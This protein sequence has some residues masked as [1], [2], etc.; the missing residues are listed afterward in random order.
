MTRASR[1]SSASLLQLQEKEPTAGG[2]GGGGGGS[3]SSISAGGPASATSPHKQHPQHQLPQQQQQQAMAPLPPRVLQVA[4][5]LN[6]TE[7]Q[8][9]M[10]AAIERTRGLD[11]QEAGEADMLRLSQIRCDVSEEARKVEGM[12]APGMRILLE[13]TAK[14]AVYVLGCPLA[15][16]KKSPSLFFFTVSLRQRTPT[17]PRP[18]CTTRTTSSTR[19]DEHRGCRLSGWPTSSRRWTLVCARST[20]SCLG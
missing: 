12:L 9:D 10:V 15:S 3:S 13:E 11:E 4:P 7:W 1:T 8:R 6:V 16:L 17:L 2:G 19:G 18:S 20:M 14:S 5:V